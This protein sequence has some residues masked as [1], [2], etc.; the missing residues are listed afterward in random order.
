MSKLGHNERISIM[1]KIV[2][3]AWSFLLLLLGSTKAQSHCDLKLP[4]L[5]SQSR[6]YRIGVLA[7]HSVEKQTEQWQLTFS[8]YLSATA[9]SKFDPPVSFEMVAVPFGL[10]RDPV[11][12]FIKGDYDFVF[13][14]PGMFSCIDTEVGM[15]TLTSIISRRKVNDEV[16]SLNKFGGVIF[17]WAGNDEINGVLDLKDK[18][19]GLVSIGGLGR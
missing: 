7:I 14:N 17:T 19:L 4:L 10:E 2:T 6:V 5:S 1:K 3:I 13:T 11:D 16:Y 8:D 15:H 18:R 9:G 12:E